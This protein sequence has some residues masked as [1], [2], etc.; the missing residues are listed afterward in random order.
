M[1]VIGPVV[2]SRIPADDLQRDLTDVLPEGEL[3]FVFRLCW[4]AS[5]AKCCL[6]LALE[7]NALRL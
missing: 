5:G 1:H 7:V 4:I 3:E 2:S 6:M